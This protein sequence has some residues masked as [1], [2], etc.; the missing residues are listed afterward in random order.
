MAV[1]FE[2]PQPGQIY[3]AEI[4]QE[5]DGS[6]TALSWWPTDWSEYNGLWTPCAGSVSPWGTH[7]G[8]EEYEPDA[9]AWTFENIENFTAYADAVRSLGKIYEFMRNWDVY[10]CDLT[11]ENVQ[12]LNPYLY[13][14]PTEVKVYEDGSHTTHKHM[15]MG[16]LAI[17]LPYVMPDSRTVYITDDGS[18]V[19]LAMFVSD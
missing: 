11:I 14:W 12:L 18:N 19:M 17:E 6:M 8:S 2:S 9:K 16:R 3:L 1:Q 15:A 10:P 7:M 5:M 13:G 4:Q